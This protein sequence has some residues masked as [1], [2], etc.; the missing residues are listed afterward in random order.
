MICHLQLFPSGILTRCPSTARHWPRPPFLHG[1]ALACFRCQLSC[2][3]A[4]SE[5]AAPQD[6]PRG[7]EV[8][9]F[10]LSIGAWWHVS[11]SLTHPALLSMA[12]VCHQLLQEVCAAHPALCSLLWDALACWGAEAAGVMLPNQNNDSTR[13]WEGNQMKGFRPLSRVHISSMFSLGRGKE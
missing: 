7:L 5:V 13:L 10:S 1:P 11:T 4:K 3:G 12:F 2:W 6:W 8:F 9:L